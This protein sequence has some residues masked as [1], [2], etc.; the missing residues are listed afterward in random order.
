MNLLRLERKA[1]EKSEVLVSQGESP[2]KML[3]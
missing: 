2:L 3:N 1:K